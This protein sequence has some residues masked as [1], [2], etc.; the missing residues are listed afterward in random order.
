MAPPPPAMISRPYRVDPGRVR[1]RGLAAR[2]AERNRERG[3]RAARCLSGRT[4]TTPREARAWLRQVTAEWGLPR[5]QAADLVQIVS[6]L[7]TNAVEHTR[8][9]VVIVTAAW[10]P[11][12]VTVSVT[13]RGPQRRI[14]ARAAE[15]LAEHG[16][17]LAIVGELAQRWGHLHTGAGTRVWARV[18]VPRSAAPSHARPTG[19]A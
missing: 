19:G 7:V 5:A 13:D 3:P 16:R 17:G 14:A 12:A 9:A 2:A 18:A 15:D 8:S 10:V 11:G 4:P 6:E 1:S